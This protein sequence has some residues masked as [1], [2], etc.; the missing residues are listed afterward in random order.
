MITATSVNSP[1]AQLVRV[2]GLHPE[3][4]TLQGLRNAR[5]VDIPIPDSKYGIHIVGWRWYYSKGSV[6]CSNWGVSYN[7]LER[8]AVNP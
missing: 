2:S 4:R 7:W 3:V 8:R 5:D 1:L 6:I